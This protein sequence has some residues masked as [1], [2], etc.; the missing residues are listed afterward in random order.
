MNEKLQS[1]L[2]IKTTEKNQESNPLLFDLKDEE[3][4]D[5]LLKLFETGKISRVVDNYSEQVGELALIKDPTLI[6]KKKENATVGEGELSD[7]N[8]IY[9]P[10]R[11][12]L[13]HAVNQ[14][15]YEMVRLSRNDNFIS[16]TQ[17]AEIKKKI[18]AVA[19]LNVGN[20]GTVCMAQ[21]GFNH[22]KLA[23][24]DI[25]AL[26][27]LNRFRAGL[28]EVEVDKT[29]ITARQI[30]EIN[31]YI[32]LDIY[33]D[34][35]KPENIDQFLL[36]PKVDLLIEEIDNLKLKIALRQRAREL[37]IPVL[38]VTGNGSNII[39]D[40]ERYDEDNTKPLLNGYLKEEV[41]DRINNVGSTTDFREKMALM[42]D[43]MGGEFLVKELRESFDRVGIDL[44]GIPQLAEATFLRGASLAYF[45]RKILITKDVPSGRYKLELDG[46]KKI[47]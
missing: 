16:S 3:Q 18:I 1:L 32:N 27:N 2:K 36:E 7:G 43:F 19:G 24:L 15:D 8:W 17:Q 25:L 46:I 22:L 31:P 14:D 34:G 40:V 26:S 38:M 21:E 47:G 45:A 12:T 41:I 37:K 30:Y 4:A 5:A 28:P 6:L 13:V 20:S 35:I 33:H 9:Y 11:Q 29:T 39:I 42:R 44:A 23:D 10:W